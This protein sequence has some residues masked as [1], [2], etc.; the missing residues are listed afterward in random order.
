M[1]NAVVQ[2]TIDDCKNDLQKIEGFITYLGSSSPLIPYLTKYALIKSCGT[3]EQAYKAIIADYYCNLS[4]QLSDFINHHVREASSN[5]RYEN[6]KTAVKRFDGAKHS[7]FDTA[8]KGLPDYNRLLASLSTLNEARNNFAHGYPM[9]VS[10][11]SI[12]AYFE[13]SVLIIEEL[14]KCFV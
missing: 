3:I 5:P 9:G 10:F 2:S 8:V 11:A 12:K 4:P 1:N 14:D 13:D 6:I 7:A